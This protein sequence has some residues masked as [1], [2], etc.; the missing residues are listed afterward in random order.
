MVPQKQGVMFHRQASLGQGFLGVANEVKFP[1][2]CRVAAQRG[3]QGTALPAL[4]HQT[5]ILSI[6]P[7]QRQDLHIPHPMQ[8]H[9]LRIFRTKLQRTC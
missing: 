7:F 6:S 3:S 8:S 1:N 9:G 4:G 2:A 5:Y